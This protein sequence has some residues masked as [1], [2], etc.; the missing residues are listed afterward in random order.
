MMIL[1]SESHG[2]KVALVL[3]G[4]GAKGIAHVG[5][6]K[7]LEEND[8]PID[9]VVGTSMGGIISGCYAAGF[10]A[11]K[12]EDIVTSDEFS[13]WVNGELEKSYNYYYNKDDPDASFLS[14]KLS[15]DSTFN[16]SISSSL[17]SDLALNYALAENFAQPSANANY[18]YDSLF[19]P[20]RIVAADIFT[21]QEVVM[22]EGSLSQSLRATL[23]VPFFYKP[24]RIDG[25]YL[26]DGGIYNN[27]P[28]DV[29]LNDFNP[30]VIIGVNVS[31]KIFNEYPYDN[32]EKL[33]SNS[34]LY[35]LLD[36][37][38]P[39]IIPSSGVYIEPN[40][41]GY[42]AFDFSKAEA[43]IDSGYVWTMK[44]M[45]EIKA[46]VQRRENCDSL[47]TRRNEF[48]DRNKPLLFKGI[49]YHG[50]NSKQRRYINKV[51]KTHKK[52]SLYMDDIKSGY[53]RLVSESF[54]QTIYPDIT[55][56]DEN[57][58]YQLEIFGRPRNNFNVDIGGTI[59]SRNVSQ[60]F[61][62]LEYY[63]FDNYLLKNSANF[64][65]G[66]FYKSAQLKSRL[67]LSALN[68][69][70]IEPEFTFND[71]D[72]IDSDDIL[73]DRDDPTILQRADRK[74]G[75]NIG[76]PVGTNLKGVLSGA[77]IN[78]ND[79]YSNTKSFTTSDTLDKLGLE[80]IKAGVYFMR[81]DLNRKQYPDE[82]QS[83][84]FSLSYFNLKENYEPGSTAELVDNA[85]HQ[86][87]WFRVKA[88][89]QKYFKKGRFSTGYMVEGVL[90][91]QPFFSNY[92]GSLINAPGFN[93]I[94]DSRTLLLENFRA[95][96]YMALGVRGVFNI[97]SNLDFRIAAYGFKGYESLNREDVDI[98][99]GNTEWHKVSLAG[100]A[101]LVLHSPVGP[102]ALNANY[103]DD[104]ENR[105]GV[106]LHVGFLL[107]NKR[108]ME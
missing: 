29:A 61:L 87:E 86:H 50:F 40:L 98:D 64:Y 77:W 97:R 107:F 24:I 39:S 9:Y 15:L 35:M 82:G 63:F 94:Q 70:Y 85:S 108:S 55:F 19:V 1:V 31:S 76:F 91:N 10:S 5:V 44:H 28:V 78:N 37:T 2:Q 56:D 23:S 46:K 89:A 27:F 48:N 103:Y 93:P 59:A 33:L 30:D 74:Y 36:K 7:A 81:N 80:G 92:Y 62:G 65:T 34:L 12:I 71:W 47:Y 67:N 52:D 22:S 25:K 53:F 100:N 83:F 16:A 45:D 32:D 17:A 79:L 41:S 42:T 106:L 95:Y 99:F 54:F 3:S 60:I 6:I 49:N 101:G 14:I 73:S 18:N 68:Q 21:Q 4:G 26:F 57:N 84:E 66:S 88:S 20:I 43:L 51:F 69:L 38:D 102:I 72:Y 75:L 58:A 90:S 105:F 13:G 96:N 11:D 104:N 8:I